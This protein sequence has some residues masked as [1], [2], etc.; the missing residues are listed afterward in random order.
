[1]TGFIILV[2]VICGITIWYFGTRYLWRKLNSIKKYIAILFS[3]DGFPTYIIA[4][5]DFE[6]KDKSKCCLETFQMIVEE[7]MNNN[8]LKRGEYVMIFEY[9]KEYKPTKVINEWKVVE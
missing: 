8:P 4:R 9:L 6:F 1:M 3:K 2:C 7:H 5:S